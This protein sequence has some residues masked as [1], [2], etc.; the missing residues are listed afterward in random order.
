MKRVWSVGWDSVASD[1]TDWH[2]ALQPVQL[3]GHKAKKLADLTL[4]QYDMSFCDRLL[5]EHGCRFVGEY[6]DLS[7]AL[8]VAMLSRWRRRTAESTW[9]FV[10][11][12]N[13]TRSSG[14]ALLESEPGRQYASFGLRL[15]THAGSWLAAPTPLRP[16]GT[17][18]S[19]N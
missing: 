17:P 11:R 14:F 13:T 12:P 7:R 9:G 1:G 19:T 4:H 15:P 18:S 6:D 10:D 2:N 5:K 16:S 8:W 3:A